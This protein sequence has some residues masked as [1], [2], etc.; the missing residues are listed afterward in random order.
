MD[1]KWAQDLPWGLRLP[2]HLLGAETPGVCGETPGVRGAHAESRALGRDLGR[3]LLARV[4]W[5]FAKCLPFPGLCLATLGT[6]VSSALPS[7]ASLRL[8]FPRQ[9]Q[10]SSSPWHG[11]S[12][13]WRGRPPAS[14]CQEL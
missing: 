7:P 6:G 10:R 5:V 4:I 11:S 12:G 8:L 9:R 13:R 2:G 1:R 14:S 3:P